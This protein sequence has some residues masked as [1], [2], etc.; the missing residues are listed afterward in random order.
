MDVLLWWIGGLLAGMFVVGI[1]IGLR[2]GKM[3]R[4]TRNPNAQRGVPPHTH[5]DEDRPAH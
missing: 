1:R 3:T 4:A 5:D 2:G